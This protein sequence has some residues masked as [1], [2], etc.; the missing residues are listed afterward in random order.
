MGLWADPNICALLLFG[1]IA[2]IYAEFC[3]PGTVIPA[4][5]GSVMVLLGLA[6]FSRLPIDWR[7]AAWTAGAFLLFYLTANFVKR[8]SLRLCGAACG[9]A[10]LWF[11][12]LMLIDSTRSSARI[13][14]VVAAGIAIPLASLSSY[15]FSIAI[16]ARRN[17]RPLDILKGQANSNHDSVR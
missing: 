4:V 16:Q 2:A 17:K 8:R 12:Q 15:L 14:P 6:G 10:A 9:A 13:H 1:G 11:G 3:F 5:T 7:G